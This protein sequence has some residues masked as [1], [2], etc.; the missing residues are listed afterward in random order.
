MDGKLWTS[1]GA[2]LMVVELD[3]NY[4]FKGI[5]QSMTEYHGCTPQWSASGE[6]LYFAHHD[7]AYGGVIVLWSM[8]VDGT[9]ARRFETPTTKRWEGYGLICESPDGTM[10][11]YS[12]Y[13]DIMVQRISDGAEVSLTGKGGKAFAPR[14][15]KG[16]Q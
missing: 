6:R 15:H 11:T 14:W 3:E 5:K 13:G 10:V 1:A 12:P 4:E 2:A 9:D 7:P 8:K 16:P